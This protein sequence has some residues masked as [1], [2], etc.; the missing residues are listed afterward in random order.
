[1]FFLFA[2]VLTLDSVLKWWATT[3]TDFNLQ[4]ISSNSTFSYN[5]VTFL[6]FLGALPTS[7]ATLCMGPTVL[8]K[9]Y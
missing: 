5:V 2:M 4:Y 3:A 9:V 6:C 1:L 7:L 8:L